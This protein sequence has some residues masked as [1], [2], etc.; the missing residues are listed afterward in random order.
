MNQ[1]AIKDD[2]N[3]NISASLYNIFI[4]LYITPII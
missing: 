4:L 2:K 1:Y 3:D